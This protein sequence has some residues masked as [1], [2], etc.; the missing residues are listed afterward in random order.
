MMEEIASEEVLELAYRWLCKQRRDSH[1]N[2]DVWDLRWRWPE[3]RPIL[4]RR[5]LAGTY[6]FEAVRRYR[7]PGETVEG[8]SSPDALVLKA[9]AIVLSRRLGPHLSGRCY[10]LAGRGGAKAAVRDVAQ[11]LSA[12]TYGFRTDVKRYYAGIDHE[13]LFSQLQKHITDSRVLALLWA[14]MRR[15]IYDDG[16]FEDVTKGISLGCPLSPLMAAL[17]LKPLDD[18]MAD[19]GLFYARF[20]DDWVILS[21]TRWKLRKAIRRVNAI[22]AELKVQKHPDKTFIG[23]ISRG[24]D[25]LGYTFSSVGLTGIARRT[26]ERFVERAGR[27]YEQGAGEERIG[28][29]VRRWLRWAGMGLGRFDNRRINAAA[30]EAV[31]VVGIGRAMQRRPTAALVSAGGGRPGVRETAQSLWPRDRSGGLSRGRIAWNP[32]GGRV[33]RRSNFSGRISSPLRMLFADLPAVTS[34]D[35]A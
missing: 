3:I 16:L 35:E 31:S 14:Y 29:Y 10:H 17:Y 6:R 28:Q 8:W 2:N 7:L 9:V 32:S 18:A 4:Q 1:A 25:F 26:V 11:R 21:P 23:R 27:L 24:F 30:A 22:L 19:G 5:L 34:E 15:T 20:M 12:N 13:I 33:G